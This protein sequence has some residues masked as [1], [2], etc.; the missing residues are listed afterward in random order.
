MELEG[1]LAILKERHNPNWGSCQ[2]PNVVTKENVNESCG[3]WFG[4]RTLLELAL[5]YI[6]TKQTIIPFLINLGANITPNCILNKDYGPVFLDLGMNPNIPYSTD[7]PEMMSVFETHILFMKNI[8]LGNMLIDY[9]GKPT[10]GWAHFKVQYFGLLG[11]GDKVIS[12]Q[13][14]S[15]LSDRRVQECRKSLLALLSACT[16]SSSHTKGPFGALRGV[17][18][19]IASQVWAMRGGEGCGPRGHTWILKL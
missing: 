14:Y 16:N 3:S 8:S 4:N 11:R 5:D 18:I 7:S 19:Q 9:G 1:F 13:A 12:Y 10:G 17:M 2:I 6:E 15:L